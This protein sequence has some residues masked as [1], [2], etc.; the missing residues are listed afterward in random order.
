ADKIIRIPA[1][2]FDRIRDRDPKES[3]PQYKNF[4]IRYAMVILELENRKPISIARIDYGYLAF[5]SEG[6]VDQ[7]F[8]DAENLTAV[9]MIP[10][11][12]FPGESPNIVHACNKFA[13]KRFK[14][15][16][17]WLPTPELEQTIC[18]EAFK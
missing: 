6:R 15:E 8:L 17:T 1:T 13:E 12:P 11:I 16:F 4:R 10:P 3:F 2:R 14:N 5:D 18:D 9:S 7:K